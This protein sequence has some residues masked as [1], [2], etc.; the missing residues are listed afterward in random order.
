MK[1]PLAALC[2]LSL[3]SP[4]FA[5]VTY[6]TDSRIVQAVNS[7]GQNSAHTPSIPFAPFNDTVHTNS[8]FP[9]GTC[10]SDSMQNSQM[11]SLLMS[12][13]GSVNASSETKS[14]SAL[15]FAGS[16]TS[17]FEVVFKPDTNGNIHLTGQFAGTAGKS[18]FVA[19]L[20]LGTTSLFSKSTP[21]AIDLTSYVRQG[22]QYKLTVSCSANTL[23]TWTGTPATVSSS[24]TVSFNSAFAANTCVGDLNNDGVVDDLDFLIFLPAYNLL[25]CADGSM[26]AGCPADFN[27]DGVV[28]DADFTIFIPA[29]NDLLCP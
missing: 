23:L 10:T 9:E 16:G 27:N 7:F 18:T 11:N 12:G 6:V 14:S 26:P 22:Q 19:T 17:R 3:S 15:V 25:D 29:Y 24:A 5:G 2:L 20:K 13:S 8:D 28:D 1:R 21:G 4:A